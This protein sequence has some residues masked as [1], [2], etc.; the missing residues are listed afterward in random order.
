M[1]H[2]V[3]VLS[4]PS[5]DLSAIGNPRWDQWYLAGEP[6]HN[7][8]LAANDGNHQHE[9]DEMGFIHDFTIDPLTT[10]W[11]ESLT[12]QN[13]LPI[14]HDSQ[15]TNRESFSSS[16]EY[17]LYSSPIETKPKRRRS[18]RKKDEA[19]R[20]P[21]EDIATKKHQV[22]APIAIPENTHTYGTTNEATSLSSETSA[23]TS[24]VRERNRRAAN[25]V[26]Y[27]QREAEKSLESTEKD[28]DKAHRDLTACVQ[29]LNHEV[30]CLKLQLLQHV[31]CDC[32][33]IQEYIACEANRYIQD[34]SK[35]RTV[36]R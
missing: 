12:T 10:Q 21:R 7:G 36:K 16:S 33:L 29:E 20:S 5:Y 6:S 2:G 25:K 26:R 30:Q 14:E 32:A 15:S 8:L 27:R 35:E 19:V 34:I 18:S 31:G 3:A 22:T 23:Y 1:D 28:M 17:Q 13:S 9:V 4:D 24:K 11:A